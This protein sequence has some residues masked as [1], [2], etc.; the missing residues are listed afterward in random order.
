MSATRPGL[1]GVA[2]LLAC[3]GCEGER[4]QPRDPSRPITPLEMSAMTFEAAD[5]SRRPVATGRPTLLHLWATWCAPCR[6]ELP[7]LLELA[8]E[9]RHVEVVAV[10]SESWPRIRAH[11]DGDV[12]EWIARD[13]DGELARA[14]GVDALPDTYVIDARGVARRRIPGAPG[15]GEPPIASWLRTY[16]EGIGSPASERGNR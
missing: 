8:A 15:W 6:R 12:P 14:L 10:S 4:Q 13:P 7:D 3:L 11:F 5:G 16:D 9:M 1:L 2:L